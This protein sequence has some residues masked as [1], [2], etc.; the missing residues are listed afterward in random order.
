MAWYSLFK[1]KQQEMPEF[2]ETAEPSLKP[3]NMEEPKEDRDLK[4]L[5]T[6]LDII[7]I[8]LDNIDRRL[9]RIEE[10]AK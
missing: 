6:K 8:K 9:Q 7:T 3:Y 4:L 10:L 5:I 2:K 1:K